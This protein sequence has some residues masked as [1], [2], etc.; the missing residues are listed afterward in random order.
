MGYAIFT[1]RKLMLTQRINQINFRI[2]QLSQQQQTLAD[3]AA[4]MERSMASMKNMFS[5]IGNIFQMG[6]TMQ[7]NMQLAAANQAV[8]NANGDFTN[9]NVETSIKG[10]LG[11]YLNGGNNF[12]STPLGLSL[13][14]TNQAMETVN[15]SKLQQIKDMETQIEL[16]RKSLETQLAAAQKELESVE[17]AEEKQI[18]NSAPKFA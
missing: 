16:Q 8:Q 6:M 12:L 11:T 1:A 14:A 18:E 7:Y 2:M 17:K 15:E 10:L 4:R 5:N 3:N 13:M 9:A